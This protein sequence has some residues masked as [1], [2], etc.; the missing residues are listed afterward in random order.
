MRAVGW[1]V[2]QA[3]CERLCDAE[4]EASKAASGHN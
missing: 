4:W 3:E 2:I 1:Q